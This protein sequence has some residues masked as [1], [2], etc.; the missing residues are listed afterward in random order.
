MVE[1][2][3]NSHACCVSLATAAADPLNPKVYHNYDNCCGERIFF[4]VKFGVSLQMCRELSPQYQQ[5]QHQQQTGVVVKFFEIKTTARLCNQH[6]IPH[7]SSSVLTPTYHIVFITN[8]ILLSL[9]EFQRHETFK[10]YIG[11]MS[12][13]NKKYQT[14]HCFE[15]IL[16]VF[17]LLASR[18]VILK[19]SLYLGGSG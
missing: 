7:S 17:Q 12:H 9:S 2:L 11:P 6:N 19:R 4:F 5:K 18:P 16:V 1:K 10:L 8:L 3:T 13:Q 15:Q 14:R